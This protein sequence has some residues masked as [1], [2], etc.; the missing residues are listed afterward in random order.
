MIGSDERIAL[1]G[2]I[3][4]LSSAERTVVIGIYIL[5]LKQID[6]AQQIGISTR[7]VRRLQQRALTTLKRTLIE[8]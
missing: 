5:G 7:H 3:A 6:V 1:V 2:A 8:H 4:L